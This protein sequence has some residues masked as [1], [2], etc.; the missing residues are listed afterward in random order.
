MLGAEL[1]LVDYESTESLSHALKGLTVDALINTLGGV[2]VEI[3]NRL[4]HIAL[5]ECGIPVYFLSEF[6]V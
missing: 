3:Q 4:A 6:G 1:I 5:K 2:S